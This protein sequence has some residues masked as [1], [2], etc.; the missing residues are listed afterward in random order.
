MLN[1]IRYNDFGNIHSEES[2]HWNDTQIKNFK[3]PQRRKKE[4]DSFGHNIY[5]TLVY[6]IPQRRETRFFWA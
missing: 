4:E 2:S 3:F 6:F 5:D 1:I